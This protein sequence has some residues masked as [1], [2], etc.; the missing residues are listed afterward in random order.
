MI[1]NTKENKAQ[2][3]AI[4][5]L[6]IEEMRYLRDDASG[7]KTFSMIVK[8]FKGLISRQ[9]VTAWLKEYPFISR[10]MSTKCKK[11]SKDYLRRY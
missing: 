10:L 9:N 7:L 1:I 4:L 8:D 3:K 5:K 2:L 6:Y 11:H